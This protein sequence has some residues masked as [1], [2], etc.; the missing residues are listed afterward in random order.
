ML[1]IC[2]A[3]HCEFWLFLPEIRDKSERIREK[4]GREQ[5]GSKERV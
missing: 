5:E 4:S 1:L 2:M 3:M